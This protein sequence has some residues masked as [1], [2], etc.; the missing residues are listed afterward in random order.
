MVLL[1]NG[2]PDKREGSTITDHSL[3][4]GNFDKTSFMSGIQRH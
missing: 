2:N 3:R 1:N 4:S